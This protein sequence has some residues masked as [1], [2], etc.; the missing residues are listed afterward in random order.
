[1]VLVARASELDHIRVGVVAGRAVGNAVKRNRAKRVLRAAMRRMQGA[2][3]S[4]WD[5][6]LIARAPL[7]T[8]ES[9]EVTETL[10]ELLRR[11]GLVVVS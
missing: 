7:L 8:A 1:M 10:G 9:A 5:V 3:R 6:V 2:V 11:A 4:G